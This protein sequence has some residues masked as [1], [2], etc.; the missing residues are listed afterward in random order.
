MED[1]FTL[2]LNAPI[3]VSQR[4][5]VRVCGRSLAG[6]VVLNDAG[7]MD[8]CLSVCRQCCVLSLGWADLLSRGVIPSVVCNCNG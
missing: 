2:L 3:P 4:S 1:L 7:D 8:C 6:I 5:K